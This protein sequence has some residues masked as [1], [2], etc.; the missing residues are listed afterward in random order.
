MKIQT[1]TNLHMAE[2]RELAAQYDAARI[3]SCIQLAARDKANPCYSQGDVEEVL[4]VLAKAGFVAA[5]MEQG[6]TMNEA[7]VIW[8]GVFA[9]YR[10]CDE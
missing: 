4:N 10:G 7:F 3:E 5:Q 8:A 1:V 9:P 6:K 2:I